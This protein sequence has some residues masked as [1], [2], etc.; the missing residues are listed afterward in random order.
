MDRPPSQ[1]FLSQAKGLIS[2]LAHRLEGGPFGSFSSSIYDTAWVAM[3]GKPEDRSTLLFPQCFHFLLQAQ[4]EEGGWASY[5]SDVDGILNTLAALLA[6]KNYQKSGFSSDLLNDFE[7]RIAKADCYART[8][9]KEWDVASTDHIAFEILAPSL[10]QM[11][12]VDSE[13]FDFPGRQALF[14]LNSSKLSKFSPELIYGKRETTLVHSLEAFVGIIDFDRV[15]HHLD[16]WGSMMASPSSTAAFL[17]HSSEWSESAERYL[18]NVV[19]SGQGIDKGGVPTFFPSS[20]FEVA[21]VSQASPSIVILITKSKIDCIH[22]F[23]S[24]G[25]V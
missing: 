20:I 1:H 17:I 21:W 13:R 6:L 11:L 23:Q 12:E 19:A 9:L 25:H 10:L 22:H 14:A 4:N 8:L 2:E 16:E 24:C 5:V 7:T 15:G 3:I 18:Q